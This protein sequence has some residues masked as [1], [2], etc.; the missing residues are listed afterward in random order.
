MGELCN[1][2]YHAIEKLTNVKERV[3][4]VRKIGS[5][6]EC[7]LG[8][9][10][11]PIGVDNPGNACYLNAVIVCMREI[12]GFRRKVLREEEGGEKGGLKEVLMRLSGLRCGAVAG[13][14]AEVDPTPPPGG[15][16][17]GGVVWGGGWGCRR[18]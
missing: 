9:G 4:T 14:R 3:E 17:W 15:E 5:G 18:A 10:G 11:A 13:Q 7:G 16:V 6:R 8:G 2:F 1:E 12:D